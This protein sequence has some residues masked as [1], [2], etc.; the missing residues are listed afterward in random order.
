M[1][2][3]RRAALLAL[4]VVAL[5]APMALAAQPAEPPPSPVTYAIIGDTPYGAAQAANFPADIAEIN[6]DPDV[7]LVV[8]LGDIKNGS[9]ECNNLYLQSIRSAFNQFVDPLVYTPGDNEWTD[10]HRANNGGYLPDERLE[11]IRRI[12][13]PTAGQSLGQNPLSVDWQRSTVEN[14]LWSAAGIQWGTV[15]VTGSD[16]GRLP[17]FGTLRSRRHSAMNSGRATTRASSGSARSSARQ[18]RTTPPAS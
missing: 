15:H 6:A 12:F 1:N 4:S 3:L 7:R 9:S 5:I 11:T 10:C 13:F 14:V 17:W 2:D 18:R 16:N 8:N